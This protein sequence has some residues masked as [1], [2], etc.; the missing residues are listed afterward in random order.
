MGEGVL[1]GLGCTL[2]RWPGGMA[3]STP[4][5]EVLHAAAQGDV[6]AED[7]Q[8]LTARALHLGKLDGPVVLPAELIAF[9][10]H[11]ASGPCLRGGKPERLVQSAV[12]QGDRVRTTSCPRGAPPHEGDAAASR[13]REPPS[14]G[15]SSTLAHDRGGLGA[16]PAI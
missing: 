6:Q 11:M 12:C 10:Q 7:V 5:H 2:D 3:S 16:P 9:Q 4:A 1:T 8:I 15:S 13:V 14:D